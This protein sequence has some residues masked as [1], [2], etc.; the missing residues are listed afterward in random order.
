[1]TR[2]PSR[3]SE[4]MAMMRSTSEAWKPRWARRCTACWVGRVLCIFDSFQQLVDF[5]D[6][7]ERRF[8]SFL[9]PASHFFHAP[10]AYGL[11]QF[12][13]WCVAVH[14]EVRGPFIAAHKRQ[15]LLAPERVG[16]SV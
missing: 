14:D 2:N 7:I 3:T 6:L 9:G 12:V 10:V 13:K 16:G 5:S 11:G 1:R 4:P 8:A 15:R